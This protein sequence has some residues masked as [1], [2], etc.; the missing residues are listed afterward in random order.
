[1]NLLEHHID[2]VINE[3]KCISPHGTEYIKVTMLV[4][5]YGV[6]EQ[7]EELFLPSEWKKTKKNGY[8]LA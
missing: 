4:D 1:M 2:R 6:K 7:T 8:Y 3:E 5:C